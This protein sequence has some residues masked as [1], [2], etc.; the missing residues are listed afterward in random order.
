MVANSRKTDKLFDVD[1]SVSG[2]QFPTDSSMSV[3]YDAN[4]KA[5][6]SFSIDRSFVRDLVDRCTW[7]SVTI[8]IKSGDRDIIVNF[9]KIS[10]Q[11]IK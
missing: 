3:S 4:G 1:E 7:N 9:P 8:Q 10:E 5:V 11:P 2:F 6:F